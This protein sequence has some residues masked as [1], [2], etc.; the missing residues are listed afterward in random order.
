M[1]LLATVLEKYLKMF[2]T[3]KY[4]YIYWPC[5]VINVEK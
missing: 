3:F 1:N 5:L 2:E 4:V